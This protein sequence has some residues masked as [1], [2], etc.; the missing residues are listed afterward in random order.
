M[1]YSLKF[2]SEK[3]SNESF[4]N[5]SGRVWRKR[6]SRPA[7]RLGASCPSPPRGDHPKPHRPIA[8]LRR[9]S[10]ALNYVQTGRQEVTASL[11]LSMSECLHGVQAKA[12]F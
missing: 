12:A 3:L 1:F 9:S 2:F 4:N 11:G 5:A 8:S 6:P 10:P 7:A